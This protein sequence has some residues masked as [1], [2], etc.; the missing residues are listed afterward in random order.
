MVIWYVAS[1]NFQL[2][3][4]FGSNFL[5]KLFCFTFLFKP[6]EMHFSSND[7]LQNHFARFE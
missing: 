4:L 1:W 2:Y 5:F 6:V 7:R 3:R